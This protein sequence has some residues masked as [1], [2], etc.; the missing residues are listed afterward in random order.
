[1]KKEE[2]PYSTNIEVIDELK[3]Q[4][5]KEQ[6]KLNKVRKF[7]LFK[8]FEYK[9]CIFLYLAVSLGVRQIAF[10][11]LGARYCRTA[12]AVQICTR[13][14]NNSSKKGFGQHSIAA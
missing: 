1:M 13:A 14:R 6:M 8:I 12:R 11:V 10:I 3:L 2:I 9:F 7:S 4:I 5:K